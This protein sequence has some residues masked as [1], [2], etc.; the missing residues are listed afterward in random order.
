MVRGH[1][2]RY[3]ILRASHP[4]SACDDAMRTVGVT[5]WIAMPCRRRAECARLFRMGRRSL[6][7]DINALAEA[8]T[9][10]RA[11]QTENA[12]SGVFPSSARGASGQSGIP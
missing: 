12:S 7:D 2:G 1:R 3:T 9:G 6:S 5:R 4:K 11:M 8:S 10:V